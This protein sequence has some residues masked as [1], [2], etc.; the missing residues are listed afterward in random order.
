MRRVHFGPVSHIWH[1]AYKNARLQFTELPNLGSGI[2]RH[3]RGDSHHF[4]ETRI[5]RRIQRIRVYR[6]AE[7]RQPKREPPPIESRVAL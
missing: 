6:C 5:G 2:R 3:R 4:K 7:F 1:V